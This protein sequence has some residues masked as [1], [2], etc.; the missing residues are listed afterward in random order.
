[1]IRAGR[2]SKT[3]PV[4][5]RKKKKTINVKGTKE[6]EKKGGKETDNINLENVTEA[7]KDQVQS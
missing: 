7:S 3:V 6:R 2:K 1:M 5:E 4:R